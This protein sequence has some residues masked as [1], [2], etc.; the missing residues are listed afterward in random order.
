MTNKAH[1]IWPDH[2]DLT[3]DSVFEQQIK[4]FIEEEIEKQKEFHKL[5]PQD[6]T[7][8]FHEHAFRV[9]KDMRKTALHMGLS[10]TVADNLYWG[11]LPHDI[12]KRMLPADIW[13]TTEKPSDELKQLR[14]SHTEL[15]I[16]LLEEAFPILEHPLLELINDIMLKHHEMMDGTGYLGLTGDT[17]SA[18]IRLACI[19]ESFDGY[20][21]WRPHFG[22]RDISN[23]GVIKRM[24]EEKGP[25]FYDMALFEQFAEMK[26]TEEKN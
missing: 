23:E 20:Q 3:G 5:R 21:I 25:A 10:K 17:L 22:D 1:N 16:T 24:R 13:D 26:L 4:P 8:I 11:T 6:T 15:G 9:A 12:G 14:R 7:Y 18:P 19:I 2:F